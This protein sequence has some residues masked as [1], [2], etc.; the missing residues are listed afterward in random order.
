MSLALEQ[1]GGDMTFLGWNQP[2]LAATASWL[3]SPANVPQAPDLSS[4]TVIVRGR[5]AGRRLLE[6]LALESANN[7]QILIPPEILTV[8][9]VVRRLTKA[10]EGEP[11]RADSL[12]CALAWAQALEQ[13]EPT[14]R[15]KLFRTPSDESRPM[16][17]T[18]LITLGRH[19]HQIWTEVGA[20]D[21]S[22]RDVA[23]V[24]SERFPSAAEFEVPRWKTLADLHELAA[25]ILNEHG[26]VDPTDLLQKNA[27]RGELVSGRHVILAGV[28][29]M[30]RIVSR[31]LDRITPRPTVLVFAPESERDG[32]D[33]LGVL[34]PHYWEARDCNLTSGQIHAVERQKDQA[35]RTAQLLDHWRRSGI[36]PDQITVAV[37]DMAALPRIRESLE[38]AQFQVRSAQ[39]RPISDAPSFQLLKLV[40]DYLN[41]APD[42]PPRYES[43]AALIRHP[44]IP[45]V[46]ASWASALDRF[47]TN[48]LPARFEPNSVREADEQVHQLHQLLLSLLDLDPDEITAGQAAD[49][50]LRFLNRIYGGRT[51]QETSPEGRVAVQGLTMVRDVLVESAQGRLP[52][53]ASVRPADFLSSILS[54]LGSQPVPEPAARDSIQLVGWLE[55]VEDDTPAVVVTSF[56]EGVAPESISSDPFLPGSLR[57]ALSLSDNSM[58]FARDAYALAAIVASRADQRGT[59]ALVCP[60]F[61]SGNN[62]TRPSRLL[63]AGLQGEALARRVWHLA[64][65]HPSEPQAAFDGGRGLSEANVESQAPMES[66]YVT[67]FKTYLE[68]PRKF[69]FQNV[70]KLRS[71]DDKAS[72]LEGADIGT[73]IH[74]VLEAFGNNTSIRESEDQAAI[75]S[76]ISAELDRI[77]REKFGRWCQ[78]TVETQAQEVRRRLAAFAPKQAELRQ[79]GWTIRYVEGEHRLDGE[80]ATDTAPHVL[81]IAGK[82]DRIDFHSGLSRWR[83]ID[84]KT[85]AKGREPLYEHRSRDGQWRDLQLP[86]Y[87]K[88]AAP[89]ALEQWGVTLTIENCELAYFLLPNETRQA[90]IALFPAQFIPE[91]WEKASEVGSRIQ[92]GEFHDNPPL[93]LNRNDPAMLAL[94]GQVGVV[95]T[96]TLPVASGV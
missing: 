77:V 82:I 7:H 43:V 92:R 76:F 57:Q 3:L 1:S 64:G 39:G 88:L 84:Y 81:R 78:P 13:A 29:E 8:S 41:R 36:S 6:L 32:F 79:Q 45:N 47:A 26:L 14:E 5:R 89:Y 19:L 27:H 58:R 4:A 86:L 31:F 35:L 55:L 22:L 23:R 28:A 49:W 75:W 21:L 56:H 74:E 91:A 87:L 37:P 83:I 34:V 2:F 70:L 80:I 95:S 59:V 51:E 53:P 68:S 90:G 67:A 60:R 69:Y 50:T 9:Q 54:F 10:S 16:G 38:N 30:P 71:E 18:N 72:E 62:P 61:D 48:H 12:S 96:D 42:E 73:L 94:C 20:A 24:V 85:A 17:F 66:I 93:D 46:G 11:R 63:L 15:E 44:D 25:A 52:W 40:A 33:D 65:K